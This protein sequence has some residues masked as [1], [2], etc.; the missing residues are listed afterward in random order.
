[1]VFDYRFQWHFEKAEN[2]G[3]PLN[4]AY[5]NFAISVTPDGNSLIVGNI[6]TQ[7]E[8]PMQGVSISHLQNDKWNYPEPLKINN[9]YNK[10]RY[11]HFT[12]QMILKHYFLV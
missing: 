11:S 1:M 8:P 2:I 3:P 9:Y 6:Y 4:N 7:N 10:S 5:S 12:M